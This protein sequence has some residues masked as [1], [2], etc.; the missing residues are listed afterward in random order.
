MASVD[1][2]DRDDVLDVFGQRAEPGEPL[3]AREVAEAADAD[4]A[5]VRDRLRSLTDRGKLGSKLVRDRTR[6]WWRPA[7]AGSR[8]PRSRTGD[9][10]GSPVQHDQF[11]TEVERLIESS[12]TGMVVVDVSGEIS[13]VN[14]R[15]E[16]ILGVEA[17]DITGRTYEQPDLDVYDEDGTPVSPD[18][19]PV[20]RV[21]E[22]GEPLC[23]FE[24]WIRLP[25][26]R[27]RWL[28]TNAV[29]VSGEDGDTEYVVVGLED[30]TRLKAREQRLQQVERLNT[31]IRTTQR[32]VARAETRQ[33]VAERV[34]ETLL[35][36]GEYRLSV[37]GELSASLE[38]FDVWAQA[39]SWDGDLDELLETDSGLPLDD[40]ETDWGLP[41][42]E[43][44]AAAATRTGELQ[45]CRDVDEL[46]GER[47][48]DVAAT[49]GIRSFAVVP[50]VH[51]ESVY[52]VVGLYADAV[53][54][55]DR[56]KQRVLSELG[57]VV[58]SALSAIERREVRDPT[59]QLTVRSDRIGQ[60]VAEDV[61]TGEFS[62]D[63]VVQ[64]QDSRML[65]Y[66]TADGI[67]P[68]Q[69]ETFTTELPGVVDVQ[70]LSRDGD[71]AR[72]E[73]L[74]DAESLASSFRRFDGELQSVTVDDE[75][76]LLGVEFESG[77]DTDAVMELIR[78]TY[79]NAELVSQRQ[80]LTESYY[81][82]VFDREL[83]DRQ[84]TVLEV[85]YFSGY[86]DQP[87]TQTGEQ[88]ADR[89]GITRQTFHAHLRKA[90]DQVLGQLLDER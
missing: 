38:E 57:E 1:Q 66:W 8:N 41:L 61:H 45:V 11:H 58:G 53:G 47:W 64:L 13:F 80:V 30:A 81:R 31:V 55:F 54:A 56:H 75:S 73:V 79:P 7:D 84:R 85:A 83:T 21:L 65:R 3:T 78:E 76:F 67:P 34:S 62:L 25:D 43:G 90:L 32:T 29:P 87:R 89:L 20:T 16:T 15:A 63:S 9:A 44:F 72:F 2:V 74:A 71:S 51:R 28:L 22:T 36:V 86:F 40:L 48:H 17:D 6:V 69:F 23:G 10:A 18:E 39:G 46:S 37:V 77:V 24:H 19:F 60:T 42:D 59:T 35:N 12:P 68:K 82:R 49:H 27:E 33:E 4:P 50:V 88:L 52:G 5:V 26:G 14:S 70:L